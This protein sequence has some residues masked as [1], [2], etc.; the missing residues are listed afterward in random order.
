M[1]A[2]CSLAL[3]LGMAATLLLPAHAG[4]SDDAE[5]DER[6]VTE[7]ESVG[8]SSITLELIDAD[9]RDALRLIAKQADVDIVITKGVSG[10]ITL[11]LKKASLR[12]ALDV[13]AKVGGLQYTLEDDIVIVS[14]F[15]ELLEERK[16]RQQYMAEPPPAP[17]PVEVLVLKLRYIDAERVLPVIEQLL[18]EDGTVSLL[19]TSD[20]VAQ[21]YGNGSGVNL[22]SRAG[23]EGTGLQIGTQ[24]STTSQGRPAKSHT[25]VVVDVPE[26]LERI[27]MVAESLDVMPMQVLIETRFVEILLENED[28]LG[29]D[30]NVIAGAA[31]A[32]APHT[33]PFGGSSLGSYDPNVSGGSPNGI[34]P[35]A[36]NSVT[37]P[38]EAG[39]FTFG[40]LDFTAFTA[41]LEMIKRDSRVQ[42]VSNPRVLVNDRHTATIL[43]GERFPILSANTSEFGNVTEQLDHYEP[44]GIQLVVT[45]SVLNDNEIELFVRPSSSSLGGIVQG[46]TGLEVARINSRQID[47]AITVKDGQTVV[48]GGLITTRDSEETRSVPYLGA[49]P[50]LGKL[51]THKAKSRER[52]DL[53]IFLTVTIVRDSGLTEAQQEM[54]ETASLGGEGGVRAQ[55]SRS[56]LEYSPS[57]AQY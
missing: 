42:V 53:A 27:S 2:R 24:L 7:S 28:R 44:I 40:T 25:L 20:H 12:K 10:T 1:N 38:T 21:G 43:V 39:L 46:S 23:S 5:A 11:G 16:L 35:D 22:G 33:F 19:K 26:R 55:R 54:F 29:I 47:T 32:A 30:W 3:S 9:I 18:S 34:F 14:T 6:V 37:T 52:V 15:E 17:T 41:I 56:E 57:G 31:G 45:P 51:F 50:L 8:S 49:V 48:L 13:I 4:V 36:P